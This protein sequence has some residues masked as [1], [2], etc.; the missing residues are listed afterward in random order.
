MKVLLAVDDS[1]VSHEAALAVSEWFRDGAEFVALHVGPTIPPT[2]LAS[3]TIAGGLAYPVAPAAIPT[4]DAIEDEFA[5]E[6]EAEPDEVASEAAR[7]VHG[8]PRAEVGD[9]ARTIVEVAREID[10]DLVV[11]GTGDRSWLSRLLDP[12]VSD[13]VVHDAPCSVLVVRQRS[14]DTAR[15]GD[16]EN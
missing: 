3:P 14:E 10:A 1:T 5:V 13:N 12:S 7:L 9:P 15:G 4:I 11:V 2:L 6:D 8:E 16:P